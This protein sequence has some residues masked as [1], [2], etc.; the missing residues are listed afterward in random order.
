MKFERLSRIGGGKMEN[1]GTNKTQDETL[2]YKE[3]KIDDVNIPM[4]KS[5]CG[6]PRILGFCGGQQP[7]PSGCSPRYFGERPR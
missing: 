3:V 1:K 6:C 2:G 7:P 5:W 4:V